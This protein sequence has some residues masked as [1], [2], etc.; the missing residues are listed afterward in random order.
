MTTRAMRRFRDEPVTDAEVERILAASVQAPSGGNIQPYQWLAVTD[1]DKRAAIGAIYRRAYDRYEPA[2]LAQVPQFADETTQRQHERSW[3]ASRHLAETMGDAPVH[4]LMLVPRISMGV[5]D[6]EGEMDV[7][8]VLASVYPAV[9]NAILAARSMGIGT[10][11]TTVFRIYEHE[12]RAVCSVPDRY[13]VVA[14]LPL[15]KPSGSWGVA[16]RRPA[17]SLTSWNAFGERRAASGDNPIDDLDARRE[18]VVRAH[19]EQ[20]NLHDFDAVIATFAH[21]RYELMGSNDVFDGEDDVRRYFATSR[22]MFP[23]QRNANSILRHTDDA[24][25][26]EAD[27]LGTL[28]GTDRSFCERILA[29]FIFDDGGD[30]IVCERVYYDRQSIAEQLEA[31]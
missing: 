27:L 8:S 13:E 19:M 29:L 4:L 28:A 5:S 30:R 17:S 25:V 3:A 6:D 7:G 31:P 1:A 16:R 24:V 12:V 11:L 23:D 21:P 14:L 9:Q 26:V 15:G 10:C 2:V 20:E 22:G 18:A